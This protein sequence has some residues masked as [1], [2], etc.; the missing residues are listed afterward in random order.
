MQQLLWRPWLRPHPKP[1]VYCTPSWSWASANVAFT[2]FESENMYEETM[3]QVLEVKIKLMIDDTTSSV[4][5]SSLQIRG[6]LKSFGL[7]PTKTDHA[8]VPC[9]DLPGSGSTAA[10]FDEGEGF[11]VNSMYCLPVLGDLNSS[12]LHGLLLEC[13]GRMDEFRMIGKL[14]T[15]GENMAMRFRRPFYPSNAQEN[16]K[17]DLGFSRY[18]EGE[19]GWVERVI[20]II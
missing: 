10:Y 6:W 4:S 2:R 20:T 5:G 7:H 15:R 14:E 18:D 11:A 13:T 3:V 8:V 17:S 12:I 16:M 1:T 9:L 19:G